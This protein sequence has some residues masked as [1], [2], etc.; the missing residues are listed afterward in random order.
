[1][2][3]VIA[4]CESS[5]KEKKKNHGS[6]SCFLCF[7]ARVSVSPFP[8]K[9]KTLPVSRINEVLGAGLKRKTVGVTAGY[10][11]MSPLTDKSWTRIF[12]PS[13]KSGAKVLIIYKEACTTRPG[14][15]EN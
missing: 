4:I 15:E 1:M 5:L 13:T 11:F 3:D 12:C 6:F 14:D 7:A 10:I 8:S 9:C 2:R